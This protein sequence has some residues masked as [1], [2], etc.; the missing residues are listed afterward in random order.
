MRKVVIGSLEESCVSTE[1]IK[2]NDVSLYTR[3]DR[4]LALE[5]LTRTANAV[6]KIPEKMIGKQIWD[7]V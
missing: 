3:G 1:L 6:Y 7:S 5:L 2:V 4:K